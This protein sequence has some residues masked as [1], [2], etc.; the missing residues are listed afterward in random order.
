MPLYNNSFP[1]YAV[2]RGIDVTI[3]NNEQLGAGKNSQRAA[4]AEPSTR[5]PE[6]VTVTFDYASLPAAVQYDIYTAWDDTLGFAGYTKVG[7]TNNVNGDR[8]TIQRGAAGGVNFR[9]IA[10]QEV[11]SPGVNALVQVRQ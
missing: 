11:I 9:L 3:V 4:I 2:S 8:V 10:V 1:P 7:T 5:S 6:A